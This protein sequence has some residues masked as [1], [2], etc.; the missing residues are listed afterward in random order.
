MTLTLR[1]L[2][3]GYIIG[4]RMI[5]HQFFMDN[6]KLFGKRESLVESLQN[7]VHTVSKVIG[8]EFSL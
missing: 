8:M 2:K 7:T 4:N 3:K 5:N 1:E 6:L